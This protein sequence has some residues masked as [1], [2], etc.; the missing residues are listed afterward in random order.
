MIT[1]RMK[2]CA[3]CKGAC[4]R[5]YVEITNCIMMDECSG[6]KKTVIDNFETN[7]FNLKSLLQI[8]DFE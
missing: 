4:R 6:S 7:M 2:I 1:T 3:I 8:T 5:E